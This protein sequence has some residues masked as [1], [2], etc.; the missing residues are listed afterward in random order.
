M[1][2]L[3]DAEAD[4]TVTIIVISYKIPGSKFSSR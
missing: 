3:D 1:G 2:D 4:T